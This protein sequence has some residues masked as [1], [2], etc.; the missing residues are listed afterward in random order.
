[1]NTKN[2]RTLFLVALTCCSISIMLT[3]CNNIVDYEDEN[4]VAP[5]DKPN[6]GAP[7]ISGIYEVRD[8]IYDNALTAVSPGQRVRIYG[9]NLNFVQQLSFNGIEVPAEE[10]ATGGDYCVVMV[11][12]EFNVIQS[13]GLSYTTDMGTTTYNIEVTPLPLVIEGLENEYCYAGEEVK[14]LG[15]WFKAYNFGTS[16]TK[17]ALNGQE[18]TPAEI[19]D[20]GMTITI[21]SGTAAG[22][23]I[24]VSWKDEDG[25]EQTAQLYFQPNDFMLFG[26]R[27]D[28]SIQW[29]SE[30]P[31][32][33]T[34]ET[35]GD[36]PAGT[37]AIGYPHIHLQGTMNQWAWNWIN[38]SQN[39]DGLDAID[40]RANYNLAFEVMVP[41]EYPL[42]TSA[43]G[44]TNG[45][46]FGMNLP[47]GATMCEWEISNSFTTDGL[48]KTVRLPLK[49]VMNYPVYASPSSHW[50]QLQMVFQALMGG[51]YDIRLANFR[52]ERITMTA[53]VTDEPE[54]E[55]SEEEEEEEEGANYGTIFD[56]ETVM[57]GWTTI[58]ENTLSASLFTG[59]KAGDRIVVNASAS[60]GG[61]V[62]IAKLD[63]D[64][65][66]EVNL[67]N[68]ESITTSVS[69]TLTED[70]ISVVSS[71]GIRLKG[72][73]FT[74]SSIVLENGSE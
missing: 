30:Q 52:I 69:Y 58:D 6:T 64:S 48:W 19:T 61:Q 40:N 2:I 13:S 45:F 32:T 22:S 55:N 39:I 34:Q 15:N 59:I 57:G 8:V 16:D 56:T 60:D 42:P 7:E 67:L 73:N 29:G 3:G 33:A 46:M 28:L 37:P 51:T 14:I 24:N 74:L 20:S 18:L 21:P 54:S 38:V 41:T 36:L 70:D 27:T 68:G 62:W 10:I 50:V 31:M 43:D 49:E 71:R 1:M 23:T 66:S 17:L 26:N 44:Q 72:K 35:D 65:W 4:Y 53:D 5:K 11:P 47:S 12:E 9:K 25:E 63:G